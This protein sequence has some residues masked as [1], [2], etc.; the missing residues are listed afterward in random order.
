MTAMSRNFSDF[1]ARQQRPD[2]AGVT[3]AQTPFPSNGFP[4][5]EIERFNALHQQWLTNQHQL[6]QAFTQRKPDEA[7]TSVVRM[8]PSDRRFRAPEWSESPY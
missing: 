7:G 5:P 6:W 4:P 1:M 8:D 3:S 2:A